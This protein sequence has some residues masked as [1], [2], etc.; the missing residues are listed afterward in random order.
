VDDIQVPQR[1][2]SVA[3]D[4]IIDCKPGCYTLAGKEL[5]AHGRINDPERVDWKPASAFVTP[6]GLWYAHYNESG[7]PAYL[8]P[9]Q[10]A[11][12]QTYPRTLD[13]RFG[14]PDRA[15][16]R[17]PGRGDDVPDVKGG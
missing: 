13:S 3:L 4:L 5:D 9:I 15:S 10:D 11:G 6:P 7:A 12:L 1:Y 8:L 2:Q 17:R 14:D 16:W